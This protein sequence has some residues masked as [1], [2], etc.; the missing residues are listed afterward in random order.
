MNPLYYDPAKDE[1][2]FDYLIR[3]GEKWLESQA[4]NSDVRHLS[5]RQR[6]MLYQIGETGK[7]IVIYC[8]DF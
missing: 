3:S 1:L 4:A 6:S 2:S 8:T 5:A 7:Q